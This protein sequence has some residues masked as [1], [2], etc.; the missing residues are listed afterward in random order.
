MADMT[1]HT[2]RDEMVEKTFKMHNRGLITTY[3]LWQELALIE[4]GYYDKQ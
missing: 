3:E 2:T 1:T 4:M